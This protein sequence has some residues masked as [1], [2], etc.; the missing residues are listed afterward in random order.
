MSV[1]LPAGGKS[2]QGGNCSYL[3][4]LWACR[5]CLIKLSPQELSRVFFASDTRRKLLNQLRELFE[6]QYNRNKQKGKQNTWC[7]DHSTH[8][9][10]Q[11]LYEDPYASDELPA[12]EQQLADLFFHC[13]N[14][15]AK[16]CWCWGIVSVGGRRM[17]G[18]A[19]RADG[20]RHSCWKVVS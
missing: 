19:G 2:K 6:L 12:G 10:E 8:E 15:Q 4:R 20:F 18:S 11:D 14:T 3:R 1:Q 9:D 5:I 16:I 7:Q 17:P 13:I